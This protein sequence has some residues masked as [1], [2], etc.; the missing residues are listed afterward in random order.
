MLRVRGRSQS[1]TQ[2]AHP[3]TSWVSRME[4]QPPSWVVL[5][6]WHHKGHRKKT[7]EVTQ[8]LPRPQGS[9]RSK[10]AGGGRPRTCTPVRTEPL[11]SMGTLPPGGGNTTEHI[12]LNPS[13]VL[14]TGE[15]VIRDSLA[16]PSPVCSSC[17]TLP[18]SG[19][20]A[21]LE[22]LKVLQSCLQMF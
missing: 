5:L 19:R 21:I 14:W 18:D 10:E 11:A 17:E 1:M 22:P 15:E 3:Q 13:A 20:V 9:T 6:R 8:T 12:H 16:W 7:K 2:K 4:K